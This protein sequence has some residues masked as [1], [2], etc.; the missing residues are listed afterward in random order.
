[1]CACELLATH[2]EELEERVLENLPLLILVGN[3]WDI[4]LAEILG[5]EEDQADGAVEKHKA[6]NDVQPTGVSPK[7]QPLLTCISLMVLKHGKLPHVIL[8]SKQ[9]FCCFPYG[10]FVSCCQ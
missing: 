10:T 2:R 1:M 8:H 5:E 6:G 4:D 3:H 9:A 7:A